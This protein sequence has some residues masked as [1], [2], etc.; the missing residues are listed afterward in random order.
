MR[1]LTQL[2]GKKTKQLLV[3]MI[4]V[5]Q[6]TKFVHCAKNERT[7]QPETVKEFVV[8]MQVV[9]KRTTEER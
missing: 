3:L 1:K 8:F 5:F 2:I 6:K 4:T 9:T 7:V